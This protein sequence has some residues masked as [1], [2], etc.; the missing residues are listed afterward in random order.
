MD[1]VLG[2]DGGNTKTLAVVVATDGRILGAG[3]GGNSDIYVHGAAQPA[4]DMIE[5]AITGAL[6]HAGM[7]RDAITAAVYSLAGADWQEDYAD[8]RVELLRR[9]LGKTVTIYND[10]LGAL[11]AGSPDGT[12]VVIAAGTGAA[13]GARNAQGQ[14]WHTSYWQDSLGGR[15]IGH[16]AIRAVRHADIGI[17]PPTALTEIVLRHFGAASCADMLRSF[18]ARPPRFPD[19]IYVSK[20]APLVLSAAQDGDAVARQLIEQHGVRLAEYALAAARQ[21]GIDRTPFHLIL[22]GGIF[23]HP[24]A[25]LRDAIL[26]RI[27]QDAPDATAYLSRYEP[28]I[29]AALLALEEVGAAITPATYAN[30]DAT[31]PAPATFHT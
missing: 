18:W 20:L 11:R 4:V 5:T 30:L 21:V 19:D 25:V 1:V 14:F 16:Q 12:G 31:M 13:M 29:G 15:E 22:N 9:G 3:R 10:A 26:R 8:Y 28:V 24:G 23:R 27:R 17:E 2:V 7:T 6:D